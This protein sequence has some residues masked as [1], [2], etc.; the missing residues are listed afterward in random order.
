[1]GQEVL[2]QENTS[3][4]EMNKSVEERKGE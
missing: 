3:V 4:Q 1:V 2:G